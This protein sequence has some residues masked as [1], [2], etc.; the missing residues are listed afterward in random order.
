LRRTFA[1]LPSWS[2]GHHRSPLCALRKRCKSVKSSVSRPHNPAGDNRWLQ[3]NAPAVPRQLY[4][5]FCNKIGTNAKR[6]HVRYT[7]AP[8]AEA[9]IQAALGVRRCTAVA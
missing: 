9:D 3:K 2:P 1:G 7:A 5:D 6:R 4:A 8:G